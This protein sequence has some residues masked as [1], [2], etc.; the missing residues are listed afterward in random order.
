M[1]DGGWLG[2]TELGGDVIGDPS[3]SVEIEEDDDLSVPPYLTGGSVAR[4]S[5]ILRIG[6]LQR[7]A[8]SGQNSAED[9][10]ER[11]SRDVPTYQEM[12]RWM[13]GEVPN[14]GERRVAA[15]R[16]L[17]TTV[18]QP[19]RM[20]ETMMAAPRRF[21]EER[22]WDPERQRLLS[23]RQ[24]LL[25]AALARETGPRPPQAIIDM[26]QRVPEDLIDALAQHAAMANRSYTT[27]TNSDSIRRLQGFVPQ[28][29]GST[30]SIGSGESSR[31][32]SPFI[33]PL[34][35]MPGGRLT[36]KRRRAAT[37]TRD[38]GELS[39]YCQALTLSQQLATLPALPNDR[40][41][42]Y[43]RISNAHISAVPTEL[44]DLDRCERITLSCCKTGP[45]ALIATFSGD[46]EGGDDDAAAVRADRP[47]PRGAGI[48][49]YEAEVISIG[50]SGYIAIGLCNRYTNLQRLT[51]WEPD[52]FAWH[53][54]DGYFFKS[55]GHGINMG[56]PKS[57]N[58]DVIGCG[59]DADGT[60]FFTKNG[61]FV[62]RG[63]TI[64]VETDLIYPAIGLRTPG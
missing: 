26:D 35:T 1:D 12:R 40:L 27:P 32:Q 39:R 34:P 45:E 59:T 17:G 46:G 36:H 2:H 64:P 14:D 10:L 4:P 11:A 43:M 33:T 9:L 18:V 50:V 7:E 52:S 6:R 23:T 20:L 42:A 41:P 16:R 21:G 15:R 22:T 54:D 31:T 30:S 47:I 44:N 56:W 25:E 51:G 8:E 57:G 29:V 19:H 24:E 55:Q 13:R 38:H 58:G 37:L 28:V 48:Y 5:R 3:G 62:G 53:L 60:L 63:C 61:Q 49:Y